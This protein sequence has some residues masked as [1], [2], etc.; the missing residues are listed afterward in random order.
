MDERWGVSI[1]GRDL[2]PSLTGS[3]V[4]LRHSDAMLAFRVARPDGL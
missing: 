4:V 3:A 2:R 1:C